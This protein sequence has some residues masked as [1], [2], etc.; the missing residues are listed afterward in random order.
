MLRESWANKY[1]RTGLFFSIALSI[2]H[3]P[4]LLC[5]YL[6][7]VEKLHKF[8]PSLLPSVVLCLLS[9][10][11]GIIY[12]NCKY[13]RKMEK[14]DVKIS[15]VPVLLTLNTLCSIFFLFILSIS[16]SDWVGL[17]L[18][19]VMYWLFIPW[20]IFFIL[21]ATAHV[22]QCVRLNRGSQLP[23]DH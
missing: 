15:N 16:G 21:S 2:I 22:V 20:I 5:V 19:F 6:L 10:M 17:M 11:L 23:Q 7:Y 14:S 13:I 1:L 3:L 9:A 18:S 12:C 4:L 8:D